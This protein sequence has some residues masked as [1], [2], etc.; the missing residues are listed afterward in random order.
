MNAGHGVSVIVPVWRENGIIN[1]TLAHLKSLPAD[2][3]PEILVVDGCPRQGTLRTLAHGDVRTLAAP[4]G[5]AAQMN[6]GARESTGGILFFLHADTRPPWN[7]FHRIGEILARPDISAGAFDLEIDSERP[8]FR[9][10]ERTASLRSRVT[11][12]P[13]GDQAMFIRRDVFFALGGFPEIPLME[14][15][16]FMS[17]LRRAGRRIHILPE[18]VRTSARRWEAE[19]V[20]RATL[21]NWLLVGMYGM[22]VAPERLVRHYR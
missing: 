9:I 1:Q 8:V 21:R 3:R 13:Y 2:P 22:G 6:A 20:I 12:I 4:R 16:A 15:V 17:G 18:R 11:R 5:R 14:D 19:G 7:A 10:I